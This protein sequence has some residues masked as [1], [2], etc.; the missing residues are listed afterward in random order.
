M[1][2]EPKGKPFLILLIAV[3]IVA[4]VSQLPLSRISNGKLN[5]FNLLADILPECDTI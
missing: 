2:E 5:D 4:A 1:S 3:I